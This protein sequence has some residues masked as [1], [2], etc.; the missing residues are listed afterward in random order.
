MSVTGL[1]RR[2]HALALAAVLA[3]CASQSSYTP[4]KQVV[5]VEGADTHVE[6]LADGSIADSSSASPKQ[7]FDALSRTYAA[8][9]LQVNLLDPATRTIATQNQRLMRHLGDIP[10]TQLVDC[11]SSITGERANGWFVYLSVLSRVSAAG[12]GSRVAT[13]VDAFAIDPEGSGERIPCGSTGN[14]ERRIMTVVRQP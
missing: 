6:R 10:L 2:T 7:A 9:G 11:G 1:P 8:L 3:G 4:P 5:L 14:L 12:T 13:R